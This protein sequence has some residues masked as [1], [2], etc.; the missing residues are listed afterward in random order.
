MNHQLFSIFTGAFN[1]YRSVSFPKILMKGYATFTAQ[2]PHSMHYQE[3]GF[4]LW[5]GREQLFYQIRQFVI[6]EN[7]LIILKNDKNILHRFHLK[8]V[9]DFPLYLQHNHRCK[10]DD[11]KLDLQIYSIDKFS[12]HYHIIGPKKAEYLITTEFMRVS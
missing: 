12:T 11:Y 2:S 5:K 1:F 9:C 7:E 3:E 8:N 4:Y 6:E 10:E